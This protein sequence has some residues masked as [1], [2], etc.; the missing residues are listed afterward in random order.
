LTKL[1]RNLTTTVKFGV[2]TLNVNDTDITIVDSETI[3]VTAPSSEMGIPVAV[4]VVNSH[5]E[6][7]PFIYT[8]FDTTP[9]A[10]VQTK[11]LDFVNPT[12]VAFGPDGHL[13]VGNAKGQLGRFTLSDSFDSVISQLVTTIGDGNRAIGGIA[14]DPMDTEL[15]TVYVSTSESYRGTKSS[16]NSASL[17]LN[18]KI[19]SVG[20]AHLELVTDIIT[21][22][23]VSKD[24]HSVREE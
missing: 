1:V 16:R 23:P 17:A 3:L 21:G 9:I 19:Q 20:G 2:T 15:G 13:Y 10:F 14:F 11:L 24:F 22:L 18:G 7:V 4:S 12:A 8:Y 5:G 6:S